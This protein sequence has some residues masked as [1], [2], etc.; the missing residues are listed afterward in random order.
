ML[1]LN[2][3]QVITYKYLKRV[4]DDELNKRTRTANRSYYILLTKFSSIKKCREKQL[5]VAYKSVY[6]TVLLRGKFDTD[7]KTTEQTASCGN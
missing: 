4:E 6:L 7:R 1:I 3:E 5:S 2:I